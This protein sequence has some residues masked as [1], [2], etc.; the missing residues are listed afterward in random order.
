MIF[1]VS[2][3]RSGSTMLSRMLGSHPEIHKKKTA[4]EAWGP[5]SPEHF[6]QSLTEA[7]ASNDEP[8][9]AS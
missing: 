3:P 2:Q 6:H 4:R 5:L 1:L 9:S 8:V 7:V